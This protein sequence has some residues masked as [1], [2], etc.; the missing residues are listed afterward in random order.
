MRRICLQCGTA[1][2]VDGNEDFTVWLATELPVVLVAEKDLFWGGSAEQFPVG[3]IQC[4]V[5]AHAMYISVQLLI[6]PLAS[7]VAIET[8]ENDEEK[9][10]NM[11]IMQNGIQAQAW[12][13]SLTPANFNGKID[14]LRSS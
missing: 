14:T 3:P 5:A 11:S 6:L 13:F 8:H 12:K 7:H 9:M 2:F 1:T 10:N 4:S